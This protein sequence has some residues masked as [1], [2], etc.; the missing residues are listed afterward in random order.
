MV[1]PAVAVWGLPPCLN[2]SSPC[3]NDYL[4]SC[5]CGAG[6]ADAHDGQTFA[7]ACLWLSGA[8]KSSVTLSEYV[9]DNEKRARVAMQG[10]HRSKA[11]LQ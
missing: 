5:A 2:A 11:L 4:L 6:V 7:S 3:S 9:C 10:G 8:I 1:E